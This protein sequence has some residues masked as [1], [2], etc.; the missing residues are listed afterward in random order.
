MAEVSAYTDGD[1]FVVTDSQYIYGA[2]NSP[3]NHVWPWLMVIVTEQYYCRGFVRP[4]HNEETGEVDSTF[5]IVGEPTNI[6]AVVVLFDWLRTRL[7]EETARQWSTYKARMVDR[8]LV[9]GSNTSFCTNFIY[10]AATEIQRIMRAKRDASE[11]AVALTALVVNHK[12]AVDQY[13]KKNMGTAGGQPGQ[14]APVNQDDIAIVMGQ[15]TGAKLERS[16]ANPVR[17]G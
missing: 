2:R 17:R 15:R 11:N 8:G 14:N 6:E 16:R 9:P 4:R 13:I 3:M 1:A 12:A 7:R 10:G 5:V